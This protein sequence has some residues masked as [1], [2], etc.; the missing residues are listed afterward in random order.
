MP[1]QHTGGEPVA[2]RAI[3]FM[4]TP[5]ANVFDFEVA[6]PGTNEFNQWVIQAN[7]NGHLGATH[8]L[9]QRQYGFY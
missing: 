1:T 2:E 6:D 5:E 7:L 9:R 3:R 8:G 4:R